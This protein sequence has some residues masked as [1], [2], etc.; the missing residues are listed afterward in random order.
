MAKSYADKNYAE[1]YSE[2]ITK[3]GKTTYYRNQW[4][5]ENDTSTANLRAESYDKWKETKIG[6]IYDTESHKSGPVSSSW[7]TTLGY[8]ITTGEAVATFK[9]TSARFY[10]KIPYETFLE[11]LNSPSKGKWLH[12]SGY[13]QSYRQAGGNTENTAGRRTDNVAQRARKRAAKYR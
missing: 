12:E 3:S 1:R 9:G 6:G 13:M 7:L 4:Y 5:R 10:Y 11:W 2:G 8:N